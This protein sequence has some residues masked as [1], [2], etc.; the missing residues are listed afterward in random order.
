MSQD[1]PPA[2]KVRTL[3]AHNIEQARGAM[4]SYF[5]ILEKNASKLP[6]GGTDQAKAFRAYVE[7]NVA[8]GF[9]FSDRLLHAKDFEDVARLQAEFFQAQLRALTEESKDL[10]EEESTSPSKITDIPIK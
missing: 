6:L 10:G 7:R 5:R 9:E 2:D 3:M 1:K 8:A 4:A